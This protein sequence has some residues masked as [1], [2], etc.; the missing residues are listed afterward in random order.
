MPLKRAFSNGY[1]NCRLFSWRVSGN[2]QRAFG[3]SGNHSRLRFSFQNLKLPVFMQ[4]SFL[5]I[6]IESK[7]SI[8][9]RASKHKMELSSLCPEF[10]SCFVSHS[11]TEGIE[12][13]GL[14]AAQDNFN[15]RVDTMKRPIILE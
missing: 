9:S 11:S 12:I 8:P 3:F 1:L 2:S 13:I 5:F 10:V 4:I 6:L 7:D 14:V 15:R